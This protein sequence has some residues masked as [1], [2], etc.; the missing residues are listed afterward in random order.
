MPTV[1]D[2]IV[3]R[4]ESAGVRA[5]FGVPGGGGNLDLVAAAG[6]ASL[7]FVLTSTETAAAISALAQS[8]LTGQPGAC[9]T[10]LGPGAASVV[11]GIACASLD[12]A[13]V[14]AFTDSYA[15]GANS[16]YEH[17]RL[18][19]AALLRPITR[20]SWTISPEH[21]ATVM[22]CAIA[23]ALGPPPGPVQVECPGPV[24]SA[25]A[26]DDVT[27]E[28]APAAP[29]SA[30][31]ESARFEALLTRA[32]KPLCLVGLG[33]RRAADAAAI[34]SLCQ[35]HGIPALV[36]YK[37]KG[38]VS[39]GDAWFG[40]IVTNGEIERPLIDASDLLIGVGFDPVELLPRPWRVT[41]PVVSVAPWTLDT[42]HVPFAAQLVGELA[43]GLGEVARCLAPSDWRE[44]EVAT[45]RETARSRV[46][47]DAPGLT[48][49]RVVERVAGH[50]AGHARVTVD[51]GAHMFAATSLWPVSEPNGL[52]ISNGLSTMGFA[53]PAAIGAA[54]IDARHPTV[55]LTGDG[56]LLMCAGELL[57]AARAALPVITVVFAD[58]SLS[59]I[60][61][62]QQARRLAP[63]GVALGD[64]NW[65][66]I[67]E[68]FG[69]TAFVAHDEAALDEALDQ[70]IACSGPTLIE[71]RIDR[72]NYGATLRAIRGG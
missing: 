10:T 44:D 64:V 24:A 56:G 2:V 9:L 42:E 34:R 18:D 71:V 59:L 33:A 72:S 47:I 51:A 40:G 11:N 70:A 15:G 16:P 25:E 38:V 36:T 58:A 12:R 48:A 45:Y 4:L 60:E 49:Q 7:P 65:P 13:P 22:A 50:L 67:A 28:R 23:R 6:R 55:A 69:V 41:H 29:V 68:G 62:K 21:A 14:V 31:V 8:E 53:L 3:S 17:Q 5:L 27:P 54:L 35:T 43:S 26:R 61:I 1:A 66:A 57:T 52:L 30:V 32:R 39:D 20:G 37:A 46:R 19:H 63:A